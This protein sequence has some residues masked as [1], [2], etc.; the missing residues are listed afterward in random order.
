MSLAYEPASEP[1][2]ITETWR[3]G[4]PRMAGCRLQGYLAH[5]KPGGMVRGESGLSLQG[6]SLQGYL[7]AW[8]GV[9]P[10]R[11]AEDAQGTPTQSHI[12]PSILVYEDRLRPRGMVG[13][14]SS[15]DGGGDEL[16]GLG[17]REAQPH[18]SHLQE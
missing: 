8:W 17:R 12:S 4:E 6:L 3:R 2:H 16:R 7:A 15:A 13:G 1:L 10:P 5:K 11:M 18:R 9:N 14:E